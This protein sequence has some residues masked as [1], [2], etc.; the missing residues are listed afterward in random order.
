MLT[1]TI[2]LVF[3]III[4]IAV[5]YSD[6]IAAGGNPSQQ[7]L[8]FFRKTDKDKGT[9]DEYSDPSKDKSLMRWR[10]AGGFLLGVLMLLFITF[11]KRRYEPPL[12]AIY[13]WTKY[14]FISVLLIAIFV[15]LIIWEKEKKLVVNKKIN[16][17][18]EYESASN[19]IGLLR[20]ILFGAL[21]L[22][23]FLVTLFISIIALF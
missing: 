12:V 21:G 2:I 13:P 5:V 23:V 14:A 10:T 8:D 7:L 11:L 18:E 17:S 16:E 3:L 1:V 20:K 22:I 6:I 9:L 19:N 15:F 4:T